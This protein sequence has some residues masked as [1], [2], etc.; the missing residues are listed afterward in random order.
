MYSGSRNDH[1]ESLITKVVFVGSSCDAAGATRYP[2]RFV[3]IGVR[4]DSPSRIYLW[5]GWPPSP[6][7]IV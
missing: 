2:G 1:F 7:R 4:W 3:C 6:L 5:A